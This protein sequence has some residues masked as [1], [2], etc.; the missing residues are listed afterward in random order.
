MPARKSRDPGEIAGSAR[1]G[2]G[3]PAGC[4]SPAASAPETSTLAAVSDAWTLRDMVAKLAETVPGVICTF[5]LSPDGS[6][7]MPFASPSIEEIYGL[8]PRQVEEDFGSALARVHPEDAEALVSSILDSARTMSPWQTEFRVR[9]PE[10][11]ELWIEGHSVPRR[12]ADGS[13][14]WSGFVQ[15]VTEKRQMLDALR[16]TEERNRNLVESMSQGVVFQDANGRITTMN[17]AAVRILGGTADELAGRDSSDPRWQAIREDGSP[18]PGEE[19]P[20]TVALR[21]GR[22]VHDVAMAVFNPVR[23]ERVWISVHS[24]PEFRAGQERPYRVFTT[25]D[26]VTDRKR[27]GDAIRGSEER[28]RALVEATGDW[29]WEV[30]AEG[31]YTYASGRIREVLGYAPSEVLG[32]TP[33]EMMS[34]DEAERVR[35]EFVSVAAERRPFRGLVNV[36]LHKD[37]H[38]VVLETSGSPVL[39]PGRVFCGYRG[40]DRDIS[41]RIRAEREIARERT[42]LRTLIDTIPDLVWLKDP[43]GVYLVANPVF[44][45]LMGAPPGGMLGRTDL[46][47]FPSD[48]AA[49]FRAEDRHVIETNAPRSYEEWVT[50]PGTGRRTLFEK[51]KTPMCDTD[52]KLVGVLGIGRDVTDL[53]RTESALRSREAIYTTLVEQAADSIAI[54][55]PE[56]G[57]FVE[58]NT[59]AHERLGYTREE[60]SRLGVADIDVGLTAVQ[61]RLLFARMIAPDGAVIETRHRRR[62]GAVRNARI[63]GR[64]IDWNGKTLISSIWADITDSKAAEEEI[65][66]LAA[67]LERR[68]KERTAELE[69][70]NREMESFSYAVSHDLRS[71]LR[72]LNG[73]SQM[74]IRDLGATLPD[75]S[76]GHLH[77]I[78]AASSRMS[79]LIDGLLSMSRT[80][81]GELRHDSVDLSSL[82][83]AALAELAAQEPGRQV[84]WSVEPGLVASGDAPMLDAVLRNLLGNA[85]KYTARTEAPRIRVWGEED[86]DRRFFCVADN[87]VGFDMAHTG[88][89][90]QPFQ[91]LHHE[92]EFPGLGIGLAT[93]H[94]IVQRHEGSIVVDAAPGKGATFRFT[95]GAVGPGAP[96]AG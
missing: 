29:V 57:A 60:F 70:A 21:T 46:D 89:L 15:D 28:Y 8:T 7:S 32:R 30:D 1:P 85:W 5:R 45:K 78:R 71:P 92:D 73:F 13:T 40:V 2:E 82:A 36:S 87:G 31:R 33:F 79:A 94:R 19:H 90:F 51:I 54:V 41:D 17:P 74:L 16:E 64:P 14:V 75:S 52:G 65:R 72:A 81:R 84:A 10:K 43:D 53:R 88:R 26:D 20:A 49:A 25:F 55:D 58:F 50:F 42:R 4:A 24:I 63:S 9:H 18:F 86:G 95:L 22:A 27:A 66:K 62:D 83:E 91:R 47:L 6:F 44:E 35:A 12:E 67:S 61:A 37:G 96:T 68:V 23:N 76:R 69:A 38:E 77:R 11:G 39:G 48:V 56:T 80:T 59:A 3:A 34:P 93:V